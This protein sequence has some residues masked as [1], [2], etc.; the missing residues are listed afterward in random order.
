MNG[1]RASTKGRVEARSQAEKNDRTDLAEEIVTPQQVEKHLD[2]TTT[3]QAITHGPM[4]K[5]SVLTD[6]A[7]RLQIQPNTKHSQA[8]K[9]VETTL[10]NRAL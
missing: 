8:T 10:D 3:E 4:P 9:S 1:P 2:E 7:D 5:K 6:R